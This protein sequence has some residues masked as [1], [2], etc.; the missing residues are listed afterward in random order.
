MEWWVPLLMIVGIFLLLL[1]VGLPVFLAFTAVDVL[2]IY[3]LW[4]GSAG[5]GQLIH[6]IFSS[7]S[8]FVLLPVPLFVLMGE[9]LFQSG[10]FVRA[11][12]TLD[13]WMGRLPGRLCILSI[14][15]GTLFSTLSG[16]SMGTSAMLG[17]L[18]LPEMEKRGYH[19]TIAIGSCMSGALA[20]I[21]PPS[22]L[23]V[24]MGSL[25]EVSIGKLLISGVVP[26]LLM[27]AM[28][29][30]YIVGRCT[31][32]PHL[33]PDYSPEKVPWSEKIIALVKHVLPFGT[34]IFVVTG[35]IFAGLATPTESAAMG[36]V[37]TAAVVAAY[38]RLSLAII[39]KSVESTLRITVMMFMILTGS[40]AF[41]QILAFT[42]ASRGLVELVVSFP[43]PDIMIVG[44]MQL[45][46]IILGTFMEPVSIMM[47]TFPVYMPIV[48]AFGFDP[49]WFGLLTLINMEIGMKTPPF[50]MVLFVMKGV[51]PSKTT[52]LDIYRSVT[53]FVAIDGLAMLLIMIFPAIATVL[54]NL[55]KY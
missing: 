29:V 20:M 22:A 19:K 35:L 42:G 15:G 25:M 10:V 16:S 38:K 4:G 12:D 17:S 1:A 50:G 47:I 49:I 53:P 44:V 41:S 18:L 37:A 21:I 11:L 45:L 34:I 28:Y 27:A 33:A 43:F 32:Q 23:A 3:F 40:T 39:R 31:L 54:P 6:S 14:G 48:K 46:M 2:G 9:L 51:V 52:M 55:M 5:L 30:V 36:V 26:G 7:I 13:K 24:I 8:S